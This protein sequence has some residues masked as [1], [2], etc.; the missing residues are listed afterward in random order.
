MDALPGTH[1]AGFGTP[2]CGHCQRA[3]PADP[4]ALAAAG[5]SPPKGGRRPRP[6]PGSASSVWPTL[7]GRD[8]RGGGGCAPAAS[9]G[10]PHAVALA[11]TQAG[12]R[13][14]CLSPWRPCGKARAA[15]CDVC[16]RARRQEWRTAPAPAAGRRA[17]HLVLDA[18]GQMTA[19]RDARAPACVKP[20]PGTGGPGGM[21]ASDLLSPR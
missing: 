11:I 5:W 12:G 17:D 3:Q 16:Q 10:D 9:A 21:A 20:R 1:P 19:R 7:I 4:N 6:T 8:G 14:R 18:D 15:S 13:R 2:W